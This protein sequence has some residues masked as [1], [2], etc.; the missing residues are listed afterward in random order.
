MRAV[1]RKHKRHL[2]F[3]MVGQIKAPNKARR[4]DVAPQWLV[5]SKTQLFATSASILRRNSSSLRLHAAS[6]GRRVQRIKVKNKGNGVEIV[7]PQISSIDEEREGIPQSHKSN[8]SS[9][10]KPRR[11]PN[12]GEQII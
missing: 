1:D 9:N 10:D 7:S 8:H 2:E 4:V 6:V 5:R 11:P 3:S 12:I